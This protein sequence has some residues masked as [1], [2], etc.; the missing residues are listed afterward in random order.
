MT[1]GFTLRLMAIVA[2]IVIVASVCV[3]LPSHASTIDTGTLA[4]GVQRTY[5]GSRSESIYDVRFR[6]AP[7]REVLQ[8]LAWLSGINIVIPEGIEGVV[9]VNFYEITVGDALNA[10]IKANT[11]VNKLNIGTISFNPSMNGLLTGST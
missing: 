9:N 1:R 6:A 11:E 8:F 10:I 3:S 2:G 4:R 5:M 7:L